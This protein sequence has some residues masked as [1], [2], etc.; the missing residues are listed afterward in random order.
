DQ[1]RALAL[2]VPLRK[3]VLNRL[4]SDTERLVRD[5]ADLRISAERSGDLPLDGTRYELWYFAGMQSF[6]LT[7][8]AGTVG[9]TSEPRQTIKWMNEIYRALKQP[10]SDS[11][12]K[13]TSGGL[14]RKTVQV[15]RR[16]VRSQKRSQ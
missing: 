4:P 13:N 11:L 16:K 14:V 5:F 1:L 8:Y 7:E 3:S 6:H 2:S 15:P 10:D 9:M 12:A